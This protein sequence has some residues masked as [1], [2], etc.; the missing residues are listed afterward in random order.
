MKR[1]WFALALSGALICALSLPAMAAEPAG[2][3][4]SP[5][6][7]QEDTLLPE[8]ILYYGTVQSITRGEDSAITRLD[9]TSERYGEY[10]MHISQETVWIDS[11]NRTKA[12]PAD[13]EEGERIYVF[14]SPVATMS[15]P[16]QSPA[17]AVVL[18]MPQDAGCA[19][20]HRVEAAELKNGQ[21]TITTNHGGLLIRADAQT[22]LSRYGDDTPLALTDIQAGDRIMAWYGAVASSEPAQASASHLMLLPA[23]QEASSQGDTSQE[24]SSPLTRQEMICLLH[25]QEGNPVV[26]YAMRYTDVAA[27]AEYAEA[28][29]WASSEGIANGYGDGRFDPDAPITRQQMA[30]MLYR[31]VQSKGY[32]FTGAWAFPLDFTDAGDVSEYAYE[33]MCWLTMNDI[34]TGSED[35]TLAPHDQVTRDEAQ[36]TLSRLS[37]FLQT[38]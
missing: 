15:I 19:Q 32:G 13:L 33:A 5:A 30:A 4:S 24:D 35:G 6:D 10:V 7:T 14:H 38:L 37:D 34:I 26:N 12:D 27:D 3:A 31:Y 17:L 20:Y 16:P 8:S 28:V 11:G 9:M 29:R 21:L 23:D 18:N 1:K 2:T 22:S 36:A 25:D